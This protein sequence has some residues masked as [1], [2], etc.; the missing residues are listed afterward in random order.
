[1]LSLI[2]LELPWLSLIVFE[3]ERRR[4]FAASRRR[5]ALAHPGMAGR[6]VEGSPPPPP[7]K[8]KCD[9]VTKMVFHR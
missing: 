5:G 4:A 8:P 1:M 9:S 7:G 2:N 3:S 6:K